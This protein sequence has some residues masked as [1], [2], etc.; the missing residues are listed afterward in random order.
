MHERNPTSS[1]S[2]TSLLSLLH[3]FLDS[4]EFVFGNPANIH[5]VSRFLMNVHSSSMNLGFIEILSVSWL[6][7][8]C[9]PVCVSILED[10]V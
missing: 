4:R 9:C 1:N 3:V 5:N 8:E 6:G 10:I 2:V 7:E